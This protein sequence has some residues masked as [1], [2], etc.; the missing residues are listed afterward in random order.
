MKI[1][2]L[3]WAEVGILIDELA[4]KIKGEFDGIYAIPRGGLVA[5]V[6]L[7]HK[8]KLPLL[9]VPTKNSLIVDDISD[10][11]NTL[12]RIKGKKIACIHSSAWTKTKPD[13]YIA[14][15]TEKDS[16]IEYPWEENL[17]Q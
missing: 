14:M 13:W 5:G 8:L 16:W 7:S 9:D 4:F 3:T 2:K 15:K 17:H 12:S 1:I 6:A 10:K 11:G